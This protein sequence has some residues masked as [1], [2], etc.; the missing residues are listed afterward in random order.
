MVDLETLGN[1]LFTFMIAALCGHIAVRL[2]IPGGY[3]VGSLFGAAALGIMQGNVWM[4]PETRVVIQIVA[5]AFIGCL[6][7]RSD[8]KRLVKVWKPALIMLTAL[9]FLN[10]ICGFMIWKLSPLDSLTALM[11]MVPGGIS[12]TPIVA[13]EMGADGPSVAL[14]QIVRQILG[15]SVFPSLIFWYSR[16]RGKEESEGRG[17]TVK[18]V[19]SGMKGVPAFLTTLVVAAL[20]GVIGKLSAIPSGTFLFAILSTLILKL[21]F[22]FAYIPRWPKQIVQVLSGAYLGNLITVHDFMTLHRL[23]IP[24]GIVLGGYAINCIVTGIIIRKYCGFTT[25][26][27]MLITTPAGASDMALISEDLGVKNTDVII[28]QV[29]RA[30]VVMTF[31]PQIMYTVSRFF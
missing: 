25:K 11:C 12:D 27:A 10:L 19:K 20:F 8:V 6:M 17:Y 1:L 22:D 14:L 13:A 21:K 26:E 31:F 29:I 7:E 5:G 2:K 30:V 4:P 16:W 18:R 3:L 28:L 15:I 23:L 9:L 24:F